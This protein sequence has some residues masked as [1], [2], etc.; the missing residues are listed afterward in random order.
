MK[1]RLV[2]FFNHRVK[3]WWNF[4]LHSKIDMNTDVCLFVN[5]FHAFCTR[6]VQWM[7][8]VWQDESS[9]NLHSVEMSNPFLWGRNVPSSPN[10]SMLPPQRQ[11]KQKQQTNQWGKKSEKNNSFN[12]KA[13]TQ[14]NLQH[15]RKT[16]RYFLTPY[17]SSLK[18]E[19]V[20][21]PFCWW[22]FAGG[23]TSKAIRLPGVST[24]S[25]RESIEVRMIAFFTR[26]ER[27]QLSEL[28]T[29]RDGQKLKV[30]FGGFMWLDMC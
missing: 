12:I 20:Q 24:H 21:S 6:P 26:K 4:N 11:K 19:Y 29:F 9:Q 15:Q 10:T 14:K 17:P 25:P 30:F 16:E 27:Q 18:T 1:L 13:D 23:H 3:L 2:L 5:S 7:V 8:P 28:P 22:A